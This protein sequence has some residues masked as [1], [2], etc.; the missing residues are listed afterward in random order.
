VFAVRGGVF[1]LFSDRLPPELRQEGWR[2]VKDNYGALRQAQSRFFG[3]F[4]VHL[5]GEILS[6]LA[7]AAQRLGEE[8]ESRTRLNEI[9]Q[10]L[11]NTPYAARAKRWQEAPETASKTSLT[12][13]TCH[14]DGRLA[15]VL[16]K[17]AK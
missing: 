14:E 12:C 1:T 10:S 6:G 2:K 15:N 16:A 5:R 11:A 3:R 8:E 4:P 13:Q 17:K 9:V 7:Q